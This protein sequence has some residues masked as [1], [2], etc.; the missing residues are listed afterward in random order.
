MDEYPYTASP[1]PSETSDQKRQPPSNRWAAVGLGGC[2]TALC[3]AALSF[4][5]I[6]IRVTMADTAIV[7]A[8]CD[9][10]GPILA[11]GVWISL[12]VGIC[13]VIGWLITAR[14]K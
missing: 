4:A 2:A 11:L 5:V 6:S 8:I 9:L 7:A 1:K 14:R 3:L 12:P 10:I 13:G